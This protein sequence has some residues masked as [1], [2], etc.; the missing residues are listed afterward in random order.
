M[1]KVL[2]LLKRRPGTTLE[3]FRDYYESTHSK[4]VPKG[5]PA[6]KRYFRKYLRPL[7]G[8]P[9]DV[10]PYYDGIM[11]IWF[12][13][14]EALRNAPFNSDRELQRVIKEDELKFLDV[15][16]IDGF[17]YEEHETDLAIALK[18]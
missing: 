15:T 13:D 9:A 6:A 16:K 14:Q 7:Q 1:V 8:S 2:F 11:E 10:E 5:A 17:V 18:D 4:L 12:E 3:Q